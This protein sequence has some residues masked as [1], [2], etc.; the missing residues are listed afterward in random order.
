MSRERKKITKISQAL[1]DFRSGIDRE[2]EKAKSRRE[3]GEIRRRSK[4]FATAAAVIAF[5]SIVVWA[6]FA[7]RVSSI[8]VVV[9][10]DQVQFVPINDGAVEQSATSYLQESFVNPWFVNQSKL[11]ERV[12]ADNQEIS[13][14]FIAARSGRQI[15]LE[16]AARQRAILWQNGDSLYEIDTTGVAFNQVDDVDVADTVLVSDQTGLPV[17][18]GE[19]VASPLFIAQ[20]IAVLQQDEQNDAYAIEQLI[21][22]SASRELHFT[23]TGAPYTIKTTIDTPAIIVDASLSDTL[24]YFIDNAVKPN[25]SVDLRVQGRAAYR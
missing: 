10:T 25:T 13:T 12:M 24:T 14:A 18:I 17:V 19:P 22:P 11:I 4:R 6:A 20:I 7:T 3:R 1:P 5:V 9:A 2:D 15:T 23:L 21:A 8:E 16:V